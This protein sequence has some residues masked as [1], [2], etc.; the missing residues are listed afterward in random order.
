ML[1]DL[2][3]PTWMTFFFPQSSL[4]VLPAFAKASLC[5][6]RIHYFSISLGFVV[7]LIGNNIVH[8]CY[9]F[10]YANTFIN[11][12][13]GIL[14][15]TGKVFNLTNKMTCNGKSSAEKRFSSFEITA[16]NTGIIATSLY[17]GYKSHAVLLVFLDM[18]TCLKQMFVFWCEL[19]IRTLR[20]LHHQ[21]G[22][23]AL[24]IQS[25]N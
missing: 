19:A 3:K 25:C 4:C 7:P 12:P 11:S 8:C 17:C 20:A 2:D 14:P 1:K 24:T 5:C 15:P 6:F 16:L 18:Y 22:A 23:L 21:G 13:Q 9:F 10:P